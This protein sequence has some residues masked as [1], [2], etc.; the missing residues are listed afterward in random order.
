MKERLRTSQKR[1]GKNLITGGLGFIGFHLAHLLLS[2][3]EEVVLFDIAPQGKLGKGN[4]DCLA[5][6]GL[7]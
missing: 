2:E 7:I 3:G 6:F 4:R 1:P 5:C